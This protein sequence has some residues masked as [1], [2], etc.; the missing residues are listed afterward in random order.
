MLIFEFTLLI[1]SFAL[2]QFRFVDFIYCT[3]VSSISAFAIFHFRF[4][5]FIDFNFP[6]SIRRLHRLLFSI[7]DSLIPSYAIFLYRFVDFIGC[8]FSFSI[9]RFHRLQFSTVVSTQC[10]VKYLSTRVMINI[11]YLAAGA[12]VIRAFIISCNI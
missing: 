8:Y 9:R 12:R 4:V 10:S 2:F 5:D 6:I 3:F 7:F 1:S 11:K